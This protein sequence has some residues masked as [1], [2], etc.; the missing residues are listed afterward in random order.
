MARLALSS[1]LIDTLDLGAALDDELR[2]GPRLLPPPEL[3]RIIRDHRNEYLELLTSRV[4]SGLEVTVPELIL[5]KKA[6]RGVR[7]VPA[8][9]LAARVLYRALV[10]SIAQRLPPLD[11]SNKANSAFREAPLKQAGVAFVAMADIAACYQYLDHELLEWEL[12]NQTGQAQLSADLRR[13]LGLI[14]GKSFGLPQNHTPSHTLADV[15]L[16]IIE[17]RLVRRGYRAWRFNDDFRLGASTWRE[18]SRALE[19]LESEAHRVGLTLNDEKTGIRHRNGYDQ[20]VKGAQARW[21]E[22]QSTVASELVEY[23]PYTEEVIVPNDEEVTAGAA[24]SVLE[25]WAEGMGSGKTFY[26]Y[27]AMQERQLVQDAV[28][29]LQVVE[30]SRGIGYCPRVLK[31]EPSLTPIV[32]RYLANRADDDGDIVRAAIDQVLTDDDVFVS[33]WQALWLLEAL[34]SSDECTEAQIAWARQLIKQDGT[35][36]VAARAAL[37]LAKFDEIP[38]TTIVDVYGEQFEAGKPDAVAALA[39]RIQP[40]KPDRVLK[41]VVADAPEFSFI[42]DAYTD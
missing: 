3:D 21:S 29:S 23:N 8:L 19:D 17:R 7:P 22:I 24:I 42:L 33:E 38:P 20:L 10:G 27:E 13:L 6:Q 41:A 39:L 25:A 14:A 40:A 35:R 28:Y 37:M 32:A 15:V 26:G 9:S 30:D 36:L 12:I 4:A 1:G 34:R 18:A 5:A 31:E 16:D 11:R 2:Y